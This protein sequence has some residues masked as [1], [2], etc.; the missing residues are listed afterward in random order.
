MRNACLICCLVLL[1]CLY[2]GCSRDGVVAEGDDFVLRIEDLR[3][4]VRKLG[5]SASYDG[6]F[7]DRLGVVHSLAARAYLA[8]EALRLGLGLEDVA[9]VEAEAAN[10]ALAEAYH[11]WRID[12]RVSTPR[13]ELKPWIEK[14]DRKLYL[15]D[16]VFAAYP[17]AEEVMAMLHSG[18]DFDTLAADIADRPDVTL[19]DM[20]WLAWKGLQRDVANVVFRLDRGSVSDIIPGADGYHIFYLVDDEEFGIGIELLALRSRR[21]VAAMETEELVRDER[22]KLRKKYGVTFL[23]NGVAAAL[24]A[25]RI[26]FEGSRPPDSLMLKVVATHEAGEVAVADLFNAY[27]SMQMQSRPYVGD[28]HAVIEFAVEIM[29]PGLEAL[30][31]E[32]A[33]LGK[34]WEVRWARKNAREDLLVSLMENHFTTGIEVTEADLT[35]YYDQNRDRIQTPGSFHARRILLESRADVPEVQSRLRAGQG[36]GDV[37]RDLSTD[38]YTSAKGGDLG[39]INFGIAAVYDSVVASLQPGEVS[40]PFET[41]AGIEIIRLEAREEPRSLTYEEARQSIEVYIAS[42]RANDLLSEWVSSKKTEAGF[43]VNEDLLRRITLPEPE[44]RS[45]VR[46]VTKTVDMSGEESAE[47]TTEGASEEPVGEPGDESGGTPDAKSGEMP[48]AGSGGE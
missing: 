29:L 31:G 23:D 46:S 47:E 48:A 37:A 35:S 9:D 44:Y 28:H 5:P 8:D 21:F 22:L 40:E 3:R 11:T 20:G 26:T 38:E 41:P 16:L 25:F 24:E 36:F 19:H 7:E 30:A 27:F 32:D 17:A 14:L 4:E 13:I 12:S 34:L 6:S 15:K 18:H 10:A 1:G 42:S 43:R 45:R 39:E 2:L 33:G